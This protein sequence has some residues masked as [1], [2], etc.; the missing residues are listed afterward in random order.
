MPLWLRQI[1]IPRPP[2]LGSPPR[3]GATGDKGGVPMEA[4][5]VAK[6]EGEDIRSVP[7]TRIML[8]VVWWLGR[9]KRDKEDMRYKND[10]YTPSPPCGAFQEV[11]K[12]GRPPLPPGDAWT[13][14]AWAS[15]LKSP[16]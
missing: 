6:V 11:E 7:T 3:I 16:E 2:T 13:M 8:G 10:F 5:S 4:G 9:R 1:G 15:K 12:G 14:Q